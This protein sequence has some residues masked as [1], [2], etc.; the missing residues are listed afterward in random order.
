M[1]YS[2]IYMMVSYFIGLILGHLYVFIKNNYKLMGVV[3]AMVSYREYET[4]VEFLKK[5][6]GGF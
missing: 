6:I 1:K 2:A 4:I 3:T 5:L